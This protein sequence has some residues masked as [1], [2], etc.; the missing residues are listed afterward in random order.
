[1][2][3]YVDRL[4]TF[5]GQDVARRLRLSLAHIDGWLYRVQTILSNVA[6][7]AFGG[8]KSG[9]NVTLLKR[10]KIKSLSYAFPR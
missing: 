3:M 10:I 2:L 4:D 8:L 9:R 6:N 7:D 5:H 1:M